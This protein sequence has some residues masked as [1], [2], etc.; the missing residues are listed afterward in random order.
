MKPRI[1][2]HHELGLPAWGDP[3]DLLA[4]VLDH[5]LAAEAGGLDAVWLF[6]DAATPAAGLAA[7]LA[8]RTRRLRIGILWRAR[9]RAHPL[10]IAE[11][12]ATLDGL[13]GGR[14]ELA[15][16]AGSEDPPLADVLRLLRAAWQD[17]PLRQDGVQ[18]L[19][20]VPKPWQHPG[21][22]LWIAGAAAPGLAAREDAG[23][24]T[25]DPA[26]AAAFAAAWQRA[27]RPA[28]EL[29]LALALPALPEDP[30]RPGVEIPA[31]DLLL[32]FPG[33]GSRIPPAA[34]QRTLD[35][36]IRSLRR[37]AEGPV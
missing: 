14:V 8:T 16:E 34:A 18:G 19:E 22:P 36:V 13:S 17:G 23:L 11:D 2:V 24:L 5:A 37:P 12:V 6:E 29:R 35:A 1:G 27:G 10:R 25:S 31:G 15:F 32:L 9:P 33:V 4:A 7:A 20:V 28:S 30:T 21:P 3:G 26:Q